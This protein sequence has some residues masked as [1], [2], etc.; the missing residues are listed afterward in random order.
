[1]SYCDF[2]SNVQHWHDKG[3]TL[4]WGYSDVKFVLVYFKNGQKKRWYKRTE[5]PYRFKR[6]FLRKSEDSFSNIANYNSPEVTLYLFNW[7]ILFP[8]KVIVPMDV[9]VLRVREPEAIMAHPLA[10]VFEVNLKNNLKPPKIIQPCISKTSMCI[11][12]KMLSGLRENSYGHR[13]DLS[14][15]ELKKEL[16]TI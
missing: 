2:S 3:F 11:D 14:L 7:Y 13:L 9:K 6:W 5:R 16:T 10:N 8:R 15:Q 1:M 12:V 4:N